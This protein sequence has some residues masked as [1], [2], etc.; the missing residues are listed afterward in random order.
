MPISFALR[1]NIIQNKHVA[2]GALSIDKI[3]K[4]MDGALSKQEVIPAGADWTPTT[5]GVYNIVG[6]SA[7]WQAFYVKIYVAGAWRFN[8]IG[9][10]KPEGAIWTDGANVKIVNNDTV[11]RYITYQKWG[12]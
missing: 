12:Y 4:V 7:N 8:T 6:D 11:S 1:D 2:D 9:V 5:A 3:K 10:G